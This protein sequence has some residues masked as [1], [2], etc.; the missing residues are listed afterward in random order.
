MKL[1]TLLIICSIALV[2][3]ALSIFFLLKRAEGPSLGGDFK[4]N[5]QN[6]DWTFSDH[7][8]PLNILYVGYAKCP[9]V[10]PFSLN[11]TAEAFK[12]LRDK[13]KQKVQ[14][15]FISVD[16]THDTAGSVATYASTFDPSFVGLTGT[17]SAINQTIAQFG[18]SYMYEKT[19]SYLGYT[20]SHS[21]RLFFLNKKGIVIDSLSHP[22]NPKEIIEKIKE[23]L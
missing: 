4:L 19:D 2:C 16:Y 23:H 1:K 17:E 9:D 21:D 15:I 11:A 13:E 7:A 12:Q 10:C 3:A 8:K 6:K 18:A 14:V 22:R 20:I 5:Y